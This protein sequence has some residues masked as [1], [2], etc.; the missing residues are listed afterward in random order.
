MDYY[1]FWYLEQF[2]NDIVIIA[3]SQNK[4]K[5]IYRKYDIFTVEKYIKRKCKI[6]FYID[7]I[8]S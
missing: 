1:L 2:T 4:S 8:Q 3:R 6:K 5:T 7:I